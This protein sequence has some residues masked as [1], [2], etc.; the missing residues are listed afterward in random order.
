[1]RI[2]VK[3]KTGAREEKIEKIKSKEGKKGDCFLISV[4]ERPIRGA[5]NR[6]IIK[7]LAKYLDIAPSRIQNISGAT[8][9]WKVFKHE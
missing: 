3:V 5:A 1:M 9:K 6:A 7:T 4:K 8:S 2:F